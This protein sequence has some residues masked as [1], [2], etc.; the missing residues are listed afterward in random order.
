MLKII[1]RKERVYS[2]NFSCLKILF[3]FQMSKTRINC[4]S[5]NGILEYITSCI[6]WLLK[7]RK[8][9]LPNMS[10]PAQCSHI[11]PK[12][13]T[14]AYANNASQQMLVPELLVLWCEEWN[15][16][17]PS[18]VSRQ[19]IKSLYFMAAIKVSITWTNLC[20]P[21]TWKVWK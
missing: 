10:G 21:I 1:C 17:G 20:L 12:I 5:I 6:G 16:V 3:N 15:E 13:V 8:D 11:L 18:N 14:L 4:G 19:K 2:Y 7:P 9:Q